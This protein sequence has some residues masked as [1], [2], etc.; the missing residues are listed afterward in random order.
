M[1]VRSHHVMVAVGLV[2]G[3]VAATFV[4]TEPRFIG[5]CFAVGG[6]LAGGA[7]I[8]A[9]TGGDALAG[10][11]QAARGRGGRSPSRPAWFDEPEATPP[12]AAPPDAEQD[13]RGDRAD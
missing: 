8:A 1:R 5:W 12:E 4:E 10:G 3:I 7:F 6:G 2:L 11:P 9:I 13:G